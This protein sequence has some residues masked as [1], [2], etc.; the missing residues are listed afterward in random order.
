MI[1]KRLIAP[2]VEEM[3]RRAKLA[4]ERLA[5][6]ASTGCPCQTCTEARWRVEWERQFA[7]LA[8]S[9][10]RRRALLIREKRDLRKRRPYAIARTYFARIERMARAGLL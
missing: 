1:S 6:R 10:T 3:D 2:Y 8:D 5:W 7:A 4:V 9:A